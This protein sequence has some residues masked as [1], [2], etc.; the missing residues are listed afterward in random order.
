M[1]KRGVSSGTILFCLMLLTTLFTGACG[2]STLVPVTPTPTPAPT[3][4]SA[5]VIVPTSPPS[6]PSPTPT[7]V[8]T[9]PMTEA[10]SPSPIADSAGTP[11]SDPGTHALE[12]RTL[13]AKLDTDRKLSV[14]TEGDQM[15]TCEDIASACEHYALFIEPSQETYVYAFQRDATGAIYVL[16]PNAEYSQR[17]NPVSP[18][19]PLWVPHDYGIWFALDEN[20]GK[21]T[22]FVVAGTEPINLLERLVQNVNGDSPEIGNIKNKTQLLSFL[23]DPSR[24]PANETKEVVPRKDPEGQPVSLESALLSGAVGEEGFVY[25]INFEHVAPGSLQ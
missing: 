13:I 23:S 6:L 3:E 10:P 22:I 2:P 20:V 18:S 1:A 25:Q 9:P 11:T 16:F 19:E 21:E 17:T 8:P 4:T 15:A 14:L 24:G 5:T 7:E 12:L